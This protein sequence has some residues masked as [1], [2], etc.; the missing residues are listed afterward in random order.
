MANTTEG[1][2]QFLSLYK[3]KHHHGSLHQT[4]GGNRRQNLI[5]RTLCANMYIPMSFACGQVGY[6]MVSSLKNN[7][8]T[9]TAVKA[10]MTLK[11]CP[12]S[13]TLAPS[14]REIIVGAMAM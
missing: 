14:R 1:Q 10:S 4:T 11:T 9:V 13:G 8:K 12:P 2:Y 6:R 3:I 5:A 7:V